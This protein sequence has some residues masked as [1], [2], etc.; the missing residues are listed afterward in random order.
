M[1]KLFVLTMLFA[2]VG[3]ASAED[4]SFI[5]GGDRYKID[6]PPGMNFVFR[7]TQ[8]GVEFVRFES[9]RLKIEFSSVEGVDQLDIREHLHEMQADSS[10]R[11][12]M[13]TEDGDFSMFGFCEIEAKGCFY[14]VRTL[15]PKRQKWL[16]AGIGCKDECDDSSMK[17]ASQLA[18]HVAQ[19]LHGNRRGAGDGAP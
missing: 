2:I 1:R 11:Y 15:F 18:E 19:Q 7:E 17:S 16:V 8:E 13:G 14:M 12:V 5:V 9:Q 6:L 4:H 10:L 3:A